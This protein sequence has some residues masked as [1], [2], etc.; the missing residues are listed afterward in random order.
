M[1]FLLLFNYEKH[2][3]IVLQFQQL[4]MFKIWKLSLYVFEYN[5]VKMLFS[6]WFSGFAFV[7]GNHFPLKR[8]DKNDPLIFSFNSCFSF[9]IYF[10][11]ILN[12]F[13]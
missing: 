4:Y 2:A 8:S 7:L 9:H 5:T 11:S 6:N 13:L 3:F 1:P 10:R 12:L